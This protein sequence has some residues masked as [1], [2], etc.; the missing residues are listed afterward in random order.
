MVLTHKDG[1][2]GIWLMEGECY[3]YGVTKNPRIVHSERIFSN[4]SCANR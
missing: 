1:S 2:I 4:L 3:V